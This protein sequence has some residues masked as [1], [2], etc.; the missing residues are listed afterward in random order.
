MR[1]RMEQNA[2]A[3]NLKRAAGGTVDVEFVVQMLQLAHAHKHPEILVPGT[4]EAI[5][6]LR[7]SKLLLAAD[8]ET[9]YEGYLSLRRIESGLRLMNT[10]A[11]HDLPS[12]AQD[13][14][15]LA[16][17]LGYESGEAIT[18][19]CSEIRQRVRTIYEKVFGE[20]RTP[21]SDET[22]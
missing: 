15:R 20:Y 5:L 3:T 4:L 10:T 16:Y 13:L 22:L 14:N 18:T 21:A 17:L 6:Q 11:R 9:L 7:E 2:S 8:S 12:D 19:R 1:I